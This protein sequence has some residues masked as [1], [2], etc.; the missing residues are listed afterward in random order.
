[1]LSVLVG[2]FEAQIAGQRKRPQPRQRVGQV[3][4]AFAKVEGRRDGGEIGRARP[5]SCPVFAQVTSSAASAIASCGAL[6]NSWY[7]V[8]VVRPCQAG[9]GRQAG[10]PD[11][12]PVAAEGE[13]PAGGDQHRQ[14]AADVDS[15]EP[16]LWV[17][18]RLTVGS[19]ASSATNGSSVRIVAGKKRSP[20]KPCAM[21]LGA[22][23]SA[24]TAAATRPRQMSVALVVLHRRS[25][26]AG[27]AANAAPA[28]WLC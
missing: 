5:P 25:R 9:D 14:I 3:A 13:V 12:L 27:A 8:P 18:F 21:R 22:G 1:M 17:G 6:M 15:R 4:K 28:G 20:A 19:D 7:C 23:N 10:R 2:K 26:S 16:S 24:A 11:V